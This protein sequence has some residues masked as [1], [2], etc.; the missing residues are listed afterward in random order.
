MNP[1]ASVRFFDAQFQRQVQESD[2]SLNPFERQALPFLHG[3][4]LD[5]GCGLGNL[6]LAAARQG[7]SVVALDASHTAI[8]HLRQVA[9]VESLPITAA[10]A[11][12]RTYEVLDEYDA[13]ACIGL[14]MFFDCPTAFAQLQQLQSHV[15][16]GGVAVV[17]VL[18]KGTSYLG[19]FDPSSHCLFA[20]DEMQKRFAGWEILR[21][22]YQDFP[23][24]NETIKSFVTVI[25]RKPEATAA[26]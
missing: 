24:A 1:D 9:Q 11:D 3:T 15:R 26:A 2:L 5:F 20:R 12:L 10:E 19:M 21:S 17:N 13:V 22:E 14:L 23:A 8:E 4:V 6:S 25:A 16:P 7:C 18:V